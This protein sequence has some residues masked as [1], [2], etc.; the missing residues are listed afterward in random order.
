MV[1]AS[2][3]NRFREPFGGRWFGI[4]NVEGEGAPSAL[5]P[6]EADADREIDRRRALPEDD[7]DHLSEYY[8]ALPVHLAAIVWNS[9]DPDP[10][11]ESPLDAAEIAAVH[12]DPIAGTSILDQPVSVARARVESAEQFID[13]LGNAVEGDMLPGVLGLADD[14]IVNGVR[15]LALVLDDD[16]QT[17]VRVLVSTAT[18]AAAEPDA[19]CRCP[20]IMAEDPLRHFRGCAR[21]SPLQTPPQST[22]DKS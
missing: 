16:S 5:Y 15:V 8:Q 17:R 19:S 20:A 22:R 1:N 2:E 11:A 9:Y 13:A 18:D 10:R 6:S 4:F 7:D 3:E 12:A 21:R 14:G